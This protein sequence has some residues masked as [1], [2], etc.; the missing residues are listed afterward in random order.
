[1]RLDHVIFADDVTSALEIAR[2][3][4]TLNPDWQVARS[5]SVRS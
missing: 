1:V 3:L 5:A 2:D 4:V